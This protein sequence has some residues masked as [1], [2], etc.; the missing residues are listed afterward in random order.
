MPWSSCL[1]STHAALGFPLHAPCRHCG[2]F[3]GRMEDTPL[4]GPPPCRPRALPRLGRALPTPRVLPAGVLSSRLLLFLADS[5]IDSFSRHAFIFQEISGSCSRL[6]AQDE[7]NT[8]FLLKGSFFFEARSPVPRAGLELLSFCHCLLS[9]E[10][11]DMNYEPCLPLKSAYY[12]RPWESALQELLS[13]S[14]LT[15]RREAPP[16][17]LTQKSSSYVVLLFCGNPHE[18]SD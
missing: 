16:V 2:A 8:W 5:G 18:D 17:H 7:T 14:F 10:S 12:I 11:T 13:H 3:R 4:P 1:T 15:T 6:Q 9:V